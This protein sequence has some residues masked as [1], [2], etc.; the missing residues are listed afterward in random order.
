M[1]LVGFGTG[2]LAGF[3]G[4]WWGRGWIWV[5][6]LIFVVVGFL[7]YPLLARPLHRIRAAAGIA[8]RRPFA[9]SDPMPADAPGPDPGELQRLLDAYDARPVVAASIG[10]V[11]AITWLMLVKPF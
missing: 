7:M 3:L 4:N 6:L 10:A 8:A 11:L 2:I 1:L 5:S 9:A